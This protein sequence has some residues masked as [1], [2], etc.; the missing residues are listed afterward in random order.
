MSESLQYLRR[1]RQAA[2]D[3]MSKKASADSKPDIEN[4]NT[5]KDTNDKDDTR[6]RSNTADNAESEVDNRENDDTLAPPKSPRRGRDNNTTN[7]Q[8]N[9]P[10]NDIEMG[11]INRNQDSSV[12]NIEANGPLRVLEPFRTDPIQAQKVRQKRL[13]RLAASSVPEIHYVGQIVS[14]QKLISDSSEG[15]CCR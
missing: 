1:G 12:R 2:M 15:A 13:E 7:S 8:G 10:S 14:G 4:N 5:S 3:L 9:Q 6:R 11:I